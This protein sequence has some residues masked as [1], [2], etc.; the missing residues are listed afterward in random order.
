M[1]MQPPSAPTPHAAPGSNL[2]EY[3]VGDLS[4]A[5]K[6]TVEDAF[7]RVRVRGEVSGCKFHSS[8]HCYLNLKDQDAVL[9]AVCWRGTVGRLTLKPE[10]G[11]EVICT[12]RVSTFAP[13]SK[14]QLVIDTIELAGEGALLKLLEDRRRKLA[15]EGLFDS[16]RKKK[17]PYLPAV[18]GVITSPTGAVI[19]DILHRLADRFPRH[20]LVWPVPVQGDGAADRIAAAITGFNRLAPGG[21]VPRPDL[22]IVARGGGSLEDLWA[23]NEEV[24]VR[25]AAASGIPLISAVGHETDTTLID[26][27]S[28]MRAPTPTAAAEM[29]V[30]VRAEL[31]ERLMTLDQRLVGCARRQVADR[32]TRVADLARALPRP[33]QAIEERTQRLDAWAERLAN[34][35]RVLV[36]DRARRVD[37]IAASLP[38]PE[39]TLA[40]A[41]RLALASFARLRP[42]LLA[43]TIEDGHRRTSDIAP[44]LLT[45]AS[46]IVVQCHHRLESTGA[47]LESYSYERVLERGFVLVRDAKGAPMTAA[48]DAKPGTRL[49]LRFHD[50]DVGALVTGEGATPRRKTTPNGS[51]GTLL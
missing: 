25:A 14:Y 12:G 22:L 6:R 36:A 21:S 10:D 32:Q 38:R 39:M 3:S 47:L 28:D 31:L 7:G 41:K 50:G 30:P 26:F 51:Q 8:G 35:V 23:F 37:H 43:R 29:A 20:V 27:A 34:A 49:S 5:L 42:E 24:V 45:S 16:A 48:A 44:R 19:R 40:T 9:A 46:R 2:P 11:M 1:A 18:I 17:L 15:A 4:R 13:Q 33:R